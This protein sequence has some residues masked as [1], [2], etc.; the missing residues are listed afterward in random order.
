MIDGF[1]HCA[2]HQAA[3]VLFVVHIERRLPRLFKE[4][5]IVCSVGKFDLSLFEVQNAEPQRDKHRFLVV[6]A[7][8]FVGVVQ[9]LGGILTAENNIFYEGLGRHHQKRSGNTLAGNIGDDKRDLVFADQEIVIEIS[10]H[11]AGSLHVSAYLERHTVG[12]EFI[13]SGEDRTLHFSGEFQ[14][15]MI[16]ERY[17]LH[18]LLQRIYRTVDAEGQLCKFRISRDIYFLFQITCTDPCQ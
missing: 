6:D 18:R 9:S 12:D 16:S 7:Q 2:E 13:V 5:R 10:A 8:L 15:F 1:F 14:L 3:F 11:L 17:L 4:R